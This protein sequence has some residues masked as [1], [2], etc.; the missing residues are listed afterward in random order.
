MYQ[1][2][3]FCRILLC[4]LFSCLEKHLGKR[5]FLPVQN[6]NNNMSYFC[7]LGPWCLN[8]NASLTAH[9]LH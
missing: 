9:K 5:P 1:V 2:S 6:N 3:P 7:F 8:L 4:V